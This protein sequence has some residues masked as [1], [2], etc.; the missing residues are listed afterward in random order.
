[1]RKYT[2]VQTHPKGDPKAVQHLSIPEAEER[3]LQKN[4]T[5]IFGEGYLAGYNQCKVDHKLITQEEADEISRGVK[6]IK[7]YE[8]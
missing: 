8:E 1:M 3:E 2:D 6:A 4:S 5:E 7:E